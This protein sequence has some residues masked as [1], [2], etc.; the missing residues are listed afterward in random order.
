MLSLVASFGA[1]FGLWGGDS[2]RPKKG[3][4]VG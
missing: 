1:L 2:C 4:S 3:G